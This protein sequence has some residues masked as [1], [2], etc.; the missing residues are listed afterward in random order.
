MQGPRS[1]G[2]KSTQSL[3]PNIISDLQVLLADYENWH[4]Y[5]INTARKKQK[6]RRIEH[7]KDI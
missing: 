2:L 4:E 7:E 5:F 6:C 1:R 3:L